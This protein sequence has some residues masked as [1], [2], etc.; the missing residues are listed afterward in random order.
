MCL[1]KTRVLRLLLVVNESMSLHLVSVYKKKLNLIDSVT[2]NNKGTSIICGVR[3][4]NN[5]AFVFGWRSFI[6]RVK[7]K[8]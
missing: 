1:I 4:L 6:K 8:V 2:I 3:S 5:T 7:I